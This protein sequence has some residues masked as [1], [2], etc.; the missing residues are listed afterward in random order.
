MLA[1]LGIF[2]L[3]LFTSH[4]ILEFLTGGYYGTKDCKFY[5]SH[6][7]HVWNSDDSLFDDKTIK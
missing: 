1:F 5:R 2:I 4:A 3:V 7:R 6:H